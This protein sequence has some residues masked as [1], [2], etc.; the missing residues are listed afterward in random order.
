MERVELLTNGIIPGMSLNA[1]STVTLPENMVLSGSGTNMHAG[2]AL[3][4]SFVT[5]C[6]DDSFKDEE[7]PPIYDLTIPA[8]TSSS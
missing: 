7:A 4:T 1:N 3:A 8:G 2:L 5:K 6:K